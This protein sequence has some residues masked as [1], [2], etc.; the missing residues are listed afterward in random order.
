M[1]FV[2][3]PLRVEAGWQAV[4]LSK[5]GPAPGGTASISSDASTAW[6]GLDRLEDALGPEAEKMRW[7]KKLGK[8]EPE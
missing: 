5:A 4:V 2:L 1:F 7:N 8:F 3:T 6:P